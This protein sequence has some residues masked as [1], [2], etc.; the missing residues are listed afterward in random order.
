MSTMAFWLSPIRAQD[1]IFFEQLTES[2]T[3]C[4]LRDSDGFVW[5]GT[6][7]GLLRYDNSTFKSYRY[8]P[9]DPYSLPNNYIWA[10]LEDQDEKIWIGTF[11]GGLAMWDKEME[12]FYQYDQIPE[13]A[14]IHSMELYQDSILLVGTEQ[15]VFSFDI[16]ERKYLDI[17]NCI[18]D[19]ACFINSIYITE[20]DDQYIATNDGV[21][22]RKKNSEELTPLYLSEEAPIVNAIEGLAHNV[23]IGTSQGL[24]IYNKRKSTLRHE[25][26]DYSIV[27]ILLIDNDEWYVG[28]NKGLGH[29]QTDIGYRW[30]ISSDQENTLKSDFI[31]ALYEVDEDIVWAGTRKGVH[32]FSIR[33]PDFQTLDPLYAQYA[34]T[35][36][37][38]GMTED[39]QGDIWICS[40]EGL[41]HIYTDGEVN[42]WTAECHLPSNTPGMNDAYGINITTDRSGDLWIAYRKNGFSRISYEDGTWRWHDYPLANKALQGDGVN[43]VYQ[44]K[45]GRYWLAS[46]GK[47]LMLFHPDSQDI[48]IYDTDDGLSHPYIF[49]IYEGDE[50]T[51]WLSTANGG[52]SHFD[53]DTETFTN[54]TLNRNNPSGI[55]ANMVLSTNTYS[56]DRLLVSTVSGLDIL[57]SEGQFQHINTFDGLPNNVIYAALEDDNGNIWVS[58]NEG[59][60]KID[61]RSSD[62]NTTNYGRAHGLATYE[63]NQHSFLEHSSG[64]FLFGGAEGVTVFD[65]LKVESREVNPHIVWTD[66]Q[67]FNQSVRV[68]DQPEDEEY[69]LEKSIN[70][71]ERIELN[72]D[73]NSIAFEFAALGIN[74]T[75]SYRYFYMMDGLEKEW[76]NAGDRN[77]APYPK[78]APGNYTFKVQLVD[79]N[80]DF[81]GDERSVDIHICRPPWRTWWAYCLYGLFA[82]IS[83]YGIIQFQT[84]RTR[85]IAEARENE[86]SIF[87]KKMSRDFHDEAGNKITMISLLTDHASRKSTEDEIVKVMHQLQDNVQDLRSGMQDF[88]WV[89]DPA[90]DTLFDVLLRLRDFALDSFE[91]ADTDFTMEAVSTDLKEIE[92]PGNVRRH[93][94]L[95]FKEAITNIIKYAE[96]GLVTFKYN[97]SD[98]GSMAFVLRDDG[99]G[100]D[101]ED[102]QRVN[103]INNMRTRAEKIGATLEVGSLKGQGTTV[104]LIIQ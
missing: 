71:T 48:K 49:R 36:T 2:F 65:P 40:R 82:F 64:L 85:Q 60:S 26:S 6:Q 32:Q 19:E 3:T 29:Y 15:G 1:R 66:F 77:F 47:G 23:Y 31:H 38:L 52:L 16:N 53:P 96:A 67:L 18:S 88:I 44:D 61:I 37:A 57:D 86:R 80:E 76:T 62:I 28:T 75:S 70:E 93:F 73:Q 20:E 12:R 55:S 35:S 58:T 30:D 27:T 5:V 83:V 10:L 74:N 13:A 11:G 95:I 43:Q 84:H 63:Y 7:D 33:P 50:G 79:Q 99:Q 104:T 54:R 56:D 100:F 25:L 9:T 22:I 101:M 90:H 78:M 91:Y 89:L 68:S 8:N 21:Y 45:A 97:R 17:P 94:I 72:Y 102:L 14:S 103:G 42:E 51:L 24:Y 81:I 41:M 4:I 59:I 92:M 98:D 46:R 34:C 87:R 39:Q 69:Y